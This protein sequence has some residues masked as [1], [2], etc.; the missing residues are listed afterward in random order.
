MIERK[1]INRQHPLLNQGILSDRGIRK[2]IESGHIITIAPL[3]DEQFQPNSLDLRL[4]SAVIYHIGKE[5]DEGGISIG[6][7]DLD[8]RSYILKKNEPMD[9]PSYLSVTFKFVEK[10]KTDYGLR[11]DMRSGRARRGI[12]NPSD[13]IFLD[14]EHDAYI[15]ATNQGENTIRLYGYD[16]IAHAFFYTSKEE[17]DGYVVSDK[18]ELEE[19]ANTLSPKLQVDAPYLVFN[20]GDFA[21]LP[22]FIGIDDTRTSQDIFFKQNLERK[23]IFTQ[24]HLVLQLAPEIS[25]PNNV[26]IQLLPRIPYN[27]TIYNDK[28]ALFFLM[29]SFVLKGGWVE[30][31][32]KGNV[33]AHLSVMNNHFQ[34]EKGEPLVYALAYK[35]KEDVLRPYGATS[36]NSHYQ[37]SKGDA[38]KS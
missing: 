1:Y 34:I 36:L 38:A 11:V 37:N 19:I 17:G 32:Y 3:E 25:V 29:H 10:L 23:T 16:R 9:I 15:E 35:Y 12:V 8:P 30:S 27:N 6:I 22:K 24:R 13:I 7:H 14:D 26:A 31:G 18:K 2:A 33:T 5:F 20:A 21:L 28:Y 4:K